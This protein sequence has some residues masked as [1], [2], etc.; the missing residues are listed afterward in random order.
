MPK[1]IKLVEGVERQRHFIQKWREWRG[2]SQDDVMNRLAERM[3]GFSK[4]SL[5]R[6]ENGQQP[7]SQDWLEGIA[8]V[9]GCT[10]AQML[11]LP[12]DDPRAELM[13][14]LPRLSGGRLE[15]ATAYVHGLLDETRP[16]PPELPGPR[17]A[18]ARGRPTLR[19]GSHP[20]RSR[21]V[22]RRKIPG[23]EAE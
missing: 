8:W 4:A 19:E 15:R 2:L 18:I 3:T 21:S 7:Y 14:M 13:E 20:Q 6:V 17:P 5:S 1:R 22:Y 11:M 9:L 12:P 16:D 10:P 23:D